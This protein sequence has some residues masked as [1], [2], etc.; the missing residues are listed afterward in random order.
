MSECILTSE[1]GNLCRSEGYNDFTIQYNVTFIP[2]VQF[3]LL[4]A[5]RALNTSMSIKHAYKEK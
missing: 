5:R 1:K 4:I 3:L 2:D